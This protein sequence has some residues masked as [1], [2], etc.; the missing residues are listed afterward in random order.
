MSVSDRKPGESDKVYYYRIAKAADERLKALEKLSEQEGFKNVKNWSY[1]K[2]KQNI[3]RWSGESG[4]PR[5]NKKAPDTNAELRSKIKDIKE[6]L[7]SPSSAKRSIVKFYKQRANS[8]NK[9]QG[10]NLTWQDI[11]DLFENKQFEENFKRYGSGDTFRVYS[12]LKNKNISSEDVD[13]VN[14]LMLSTDA[15][16]TEKIGKILQI[17]DEIVLDTSVEM[18]ENNDLNLKDLH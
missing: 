10:T 12:V 6:F 13:K 8:I 18:L 14:E 2:A 9:S 5:F 1:A 17:E 11:A 7:D 3:K 15:N 16:K 4:K